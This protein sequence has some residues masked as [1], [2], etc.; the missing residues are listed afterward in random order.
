MHN[1]VGYFYVK[2]HGLSKEQI[3]TQFSL[4]SSVLGQ[5]IEEKQPFR[6]ALESGDYNRWK[7]AGLRD[8]IPGVKDNFEIYNIPKFT[9]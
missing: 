9:P 2:N 3:Y 5:S 4:A 6:A 1:V 7:P 8:L